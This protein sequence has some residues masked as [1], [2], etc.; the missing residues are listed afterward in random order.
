M[1]ISAGRTLSDVLESCP[2]RARVFYGTTQGEAV[3]LAS[4]LATL[5]AESNPPGALISVI[6]PEGGFTDEE[7]ELLASGA[8]E[9][10]SLGP[11]LL[12]VESSALSVA[13]LWSG[14][15]R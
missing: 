9:A 13:S 6:G 2:P 11:T 7:I 1:E 15:C 14:I 5:A 12:R 4:Q 3:P 8:A 10:V